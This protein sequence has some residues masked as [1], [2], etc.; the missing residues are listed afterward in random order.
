MAKPFDLRKQLKLHDNGLLRRLFAEQEAMKDIAWDALG[1]RDMEPI[2]AAWEHMADARRHFQVILQDVNELSDARGLKVLMEAIGARSTDRLVEMSALKSAAD[3]AL[4]AYLEERDAF[5]EAAIYARAEALRGGQYANRW[6]SLPKEKIEVTD[7]KIK[8]LEEEVRAFYWEKELRGE[9]CRVHRHQRP[10]GEEVFFA[11]LPDWPDK[12]LT[13]D[14]EG[15]LTPREESYTF[16]NVFIFTPGEGAV[17]IIARGGKK[18]QMPLRKA[19]CKAVM[20]IDVADD[21]P[22][23]PSFR[24]DHLLDPAFAFTTDDGDRVSAV[25]PRRYRLVPKVYVPTVEYL[26]LKFTEAATRREVQIAIDSLLGAYKL[27]RSQVA[28]AQASIQLLFMSD[29]HRKGKTMTFNVNC[30]NSCDVKSKPDDVRIVA[31]RLIRRWE[32]LH[33]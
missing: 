15:N 31:E 25:R 27:D 10:G 4:W 20:G 5:D 18:V 29:G 14:A 11:Y 1:R 21:D 32:I 13:F 3:K 24:M 22:V 17:E 7:A 16:S 12:L 19:F 28:V 30:P 26:E 2:V 23:R 8:A 33:D 6:N 9:R